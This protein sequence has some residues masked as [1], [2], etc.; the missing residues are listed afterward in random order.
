MQNYEL[1]ALCAKPLALAHPVSGRTLH[2]FHRVKRMIDLIVSIMLLPVLAGL[3][4]T[5]MIL[6][7]V[8][9]QGPVLFFQIRMGQGGRP[10]VACKFRSMTPSRN[11]TRK[12][13][14]P[15]E[16]TRITPLGAILRRSRMDE[17]P[18]IINVLKGEMSLI[19][20][21]PDCIRHARHYARHIPGYKNRQKARPGISGLAQTEIG[22]AQSVDVV[23]AKV[24][25]DL[26][27]INNPGYVQELRIWCRTF[28][29]VLSLKGQ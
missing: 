21:R 12:P 29:A 17:L 27:Y 11:A 23:V 28:V 1:V 16:H 10:F 24:R 6:N 13:F 22:Y 8:F 20:P 18:Q 15:V 26:R 2:H 9:N 25:T 4:L 7:P 19:G 14:D 3:A 5:L